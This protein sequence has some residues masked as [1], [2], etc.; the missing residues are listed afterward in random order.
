MKTRN[1]TVGYIVTT[2]VVILLLFF[3]I[4]RDKPKIANNAKFLMGTIVEITS[5]HSSDWRIKTATDAA[6]QEI[7]RL[8]SLFSSYREDSEISRINNSGGKGPVRVAPEVAYVASKAMVLSRM[9]NGAFDPTI[10]VFRHIWSFSGEQKTDLPEPADIK[11]LL[12]LVDFRQVKVDLK[13]S[14]VELTR[15][16]MSLNLGGVAKGYIVQKAVE[17]LRSNGI[18]K[19][20][21]KAGGDMVIFNDLDEV[22]FRIGIEHPRKRG[23]LLGELP[24]LNGTIATSGDYERYFT[25]DNRRYHHILDPSTG[26][27]AGKSQAVTIIAT[28]PTL[29]DGL[30]T[31][32]FVLGPEEGIALIES[33]DGVEGLIVGSSGEIITSSGLEINITEKGYKEAG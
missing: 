13:N 27:P 23:Y 16:G 19:G 6:F 15:E 4:S 8:E 10:N 32:I 1:R 25:K 20:I 14:T 29:A 18:R 5:V 22:P 30:S 31:A 11:R 7:R 2:G 3:S 17:V 24:I 21:V 26:M 33:L 9:T 12:P 28:D